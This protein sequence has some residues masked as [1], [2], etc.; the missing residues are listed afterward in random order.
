M[1]NFTLKDTALD[2]DRQIRHLDCLRSN[3][4]LTDQVSRFII[5]F[6]LGATLSACSSAQSRRELLREAPRETVQPPAEQQAE[7]P[8]AQDDEADEEY[9]EL[10]SEDRDDV[11][12]DEVDEG[13][14]EEGGEKAEKELAEEEKDD[15]DKSLIALAEPGLSLLF[16]ENTLQYE[17]LNEYSNDNGSGGTVNY[18]PEIG[19]IETDNEFGLFDQSISQNNIVSLDSS[20]DSQTE[21]FSETKSKNST[22]A[23]ATEDSSEGRA[24]ARTVFSG[25][26][27]AKQPDG[28]SCRVTLSMAS[29]GN[30][31]GASTSGC[32]N[33]Q[34][35]GV[36]AWNLR[37]DTVLLYRSGEGVAAR[38][39]AAPGVMSGL[40]T[41][42]GQPL[43]LSR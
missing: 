2:D 13:I 42:S 5:I 27:S 33:P 38:L 41:E 34:L 25:G 11:S 26:W 8:P 20:T 9:S 43:A 4:Q 7:A 39:V 10:D 16:D 15:D 35:S 23:V 24:M 17:L 36:S 18:F 14:D 29:A 12:E 32:T 40:I 37:G 21:I 28:S 31:L 3:F 30:A 1:I 22:D 6:A 19:Q